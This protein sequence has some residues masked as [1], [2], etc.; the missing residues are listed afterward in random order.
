MKQVDIKRL[1][2]VVEKYKEIEGI[3]DKTVD[4]IEKQPNE[5]FFNGETTTYRLVRDMRTEAIQQRGYIEGKIR[6]F[7]EL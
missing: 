5:Y 3:L 7:K 2:R 6:A 4:S 1:G